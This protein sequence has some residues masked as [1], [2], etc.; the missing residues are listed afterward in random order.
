MDQELKQRLIGY[1]DALEKGVTTGGE[2]V[3][4]QA[5]EV[6]REIVNWRIAESGFAISM[7]VLASTVILV[8]RYYFVKSFG[9]FPKE[10][11]EGQSKSEFEKDQQDY[12]AGWAFSA[13]IAIVVCAFSF[14]V[15]G[16]WA[17]YGAKAIFAPRLV[18]LEEI[19]KHL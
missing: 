19:R 16:S 10:K 3:A 11:K 9:K 13:L 4:E 7:A 17:H 5:P 8:L 2:F 1:L 14:C 18:I 12:I 6:C 15:A